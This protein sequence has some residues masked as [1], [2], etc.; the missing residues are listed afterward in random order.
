MH[1]LSPE[2]FEKAVNFIKQHGRPLEQAMVAHMFEDAP[3]DTVLTALAGYQ[4]PDGGFG[5]ALEPDVRTSDSS[6]LATTVALQFLR[7]L[8]VPSTHALWHGAMQ[9]L[10]TTYNHDKHLWWSVPANVSEAPHAPWW[11][12]ADAGGGSLTL[13]PRAELVGYLFDVHNLPEYLPTSLREELLEEVVHELE[14][15]P[16]ELERH[17]IQCAVRLVETENLPASWKE[18]VMRVLHTAASGAVSRHPDEWAGY[19]LTPLDVVSSAQSPLYPKYADV[20]PANIDFILAQQHSEG[21]WSPTW[22]W[23]D[24]RVT[25]AEVENDLR[26]L[27]TGHFLERLRRFDAIDRG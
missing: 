22:S 26:S 21:Y 3:L 4:N 24:G 19:T 25:W 6:V 11:N 1:H 15:R 2:N 8:R 10:S 9:Y 23:S 5:R 14:S 20:I 27:L 17:E 13:N 18:R 16:N 7:D 12:P